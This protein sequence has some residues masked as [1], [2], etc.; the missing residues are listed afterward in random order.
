MDLQRLTCDACGANLDVPDGVQFVNC[1]HCGASLQ[2]QRTESVVYT[3]VLEAIQE[4]TDRVRQNTE[5]LR[6]QGQ[7]AQ[8]DRDWDRVSKSLMMQGKHGGSYVPTRTSAVVMGTVMPGFGLFWLVATT[9]AGAPAFFS[10]FGVLVIGLAVCMSIWT[11]VKA[12]EY[13][14][15]QARYEQERSALMNQMRRLGI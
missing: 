3:K 15:C 11:F 4:N 12:C 2:V 5:L 13:N 9:N 10:G 8:L 1:R 6:L 7:L 14:D